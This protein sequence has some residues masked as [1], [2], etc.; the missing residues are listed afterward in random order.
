MTKRPGS[1][2]GGTLLI[3]GSCIGAGMLALPILTGIPGFF[4]S[5]FMFLIAWLFMV[6]TALLLV[7]VM[8]WFDEPVNLISIVS[9]TL[10]PL[11][12]GVCWVLYLFLFYALLVA[13]I[14]ASG[15]HMSLL[16]CQ[17]FGFDVPD[18]TGSLFF[19]TLFGW[20]IY[21]GMKPV[22]HLNRALMYGKIGVFAL[23]AIFGMCEI[24]PSFLLHWDPKYA[25]F[26]FPILIIS[27][28]FHN[29]V[30]V[31]M[32]Y[33]ESNRKRVR[34][35]IYMGS[36]ITVVIYLVWEMST[37]GVLP[38]EVLMRSYQMGIDGAEAMST[39]LKSRWIGWSAQT[40][41]FFSILTSF[42]AQALSLTHFLSDGLKLKQKKGEN[43]AACLLCIVP[44]LI[45][46]ILFPHLFFQAL[47]FGGGICAILLF[48]L[49]PVGMVWSGR[50]HKKHFLPDRVPGGRPLL[51]F[52]FLLAVFL[53]LDQAAALLNLHLLPK[54]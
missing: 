4:P 32:K 5:F 25:F 43:V 33:M 39:F 34:L 41:A 36:L 13:Y 44:P 50:Y 38:F 19:V 42:L 54:P 45:F 12:K 16:I 35:S 9:Y 47:N 10:G 31:L 23:L 14:S 7:E 3:A 30:P 24:K 52:L 28:G 48:G 15:S 22:D 18:W 8:G 2:F 6:T 29:M 26:T 17:T 40:L 46:T 21:L 53:F 11:G 37:L 1:V 27:F 51:F 20:L 49:F